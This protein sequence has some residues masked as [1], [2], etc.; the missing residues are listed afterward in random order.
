MYS[1]LNAS[2]QEMLEEKSQLC[3]KLDN[4]V[5]KLKQDK[6]TLEEALRQ[7]QRQSSLEKEERNKIEGKYA[8]A[9]RKLQAESSERKA[10]LLK[11]EHLEVEL[12]HKDEE[13]A[14][15]RRLSV[16]SGMMQQS[17]TPT[18]APLAQSPPHPTIDEEGPRRRLFPSAKEP[19]MPN[20]MK[21]LQSL[22][23]EPVAPREGGC[24]AC[25]RETSCCLLRSNEEPPVGYVKQLRNA[26]E[27]RSATP[28]RTDY[29]S[30]SRTRGRSETASR[31]LTVNTAPVVASA[32]VTQGGSQ[33]SQSA[34]SASRPVF[35]S[36]LAISTEP[37][38]EEI[39]YG[40][41]PINSQGKKDL[42]KSVARGLP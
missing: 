38:A 42:K 17:L 9:E 18:R 11:C 21:H 20:T 25:V 12:R 19:N 1:V 35:S 33:S 22:S 37:A 28:Q 29:R 36:G 2:Q 3:M 8:E 14:T 40:M 31:P 32:A 27:A 26:F 41:S 34:R 39:V 4:E 16:A 5:T 10:T 13:V 23:P 6:E 7:A 30:A 24:N 15:L